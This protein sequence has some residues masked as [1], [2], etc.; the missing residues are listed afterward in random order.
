MLLD[1]LFE[2]AKP[3]NNTP[4]WV[5]DDSQHITQKIWQAINE[6]KSEKINN[7]LKYTPKKTRGKSV[8][9]VIRKVEIARLIKCSPPT[10]H[11]RFFSNDLDETL[12]LFN[13]ELLEIFNDRKEKISKTG[14]KNKRKIEIL[15]EIDRLRIENTE[16]K[17]Q[18]TIE[19]VQ[20]LIKN[21]PLKAKKAA[22]L[23]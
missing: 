14:I 19:M 5:L 16:L 13:E 4:S 21:L 17:N 7:I 1:T 12:N 15:A 10:L 3:K 8:N 9:Y 2:S 23:T 18:K 6:L 20:E 22:G 11:N